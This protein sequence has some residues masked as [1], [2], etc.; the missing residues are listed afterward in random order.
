MKISGIKVYRPYHQKKDC[1]NYEVRWV[2]QARDG[3]RYTK[4]YFYDDGAFWFSNKLQK[5]TKFKAF[6]DALD[7]LSEK[8]P[9]SWGY[10]ND[11]NA[12]DEAKIAKNIEGGVQILPILVPKAV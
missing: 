4:R 3:S 1:D 6:Q 7:A 5:A 8:Y 11:V 2:I 10:K 9:K 12:V